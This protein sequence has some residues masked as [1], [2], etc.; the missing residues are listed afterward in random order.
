MREK[1]K[2]GQM[3]TIVIILLMSFVFFSFEVYT[4]AVE[5]NS[6]KVRVGTMNSF[7]NSVEKNLERQLYIVGYRILFLAETEITKNGTYI[8][9]DEFFNEAFFNGTVGGVEN[10]TYLTGARYDD[11]IGFINEKSAKVNVEITLENSMVYVYQDDPWNIKVMMVS[12]FVMKDLADLASWSKTQTIVATIP[13]VGFEDPLYTVNSNARVSRKINKTS[14]EGNY[15]VGGDSSNLYD[16]VAKSYYAANT[17]AP[18][19]L[20]RLEGN[21]SADVNGIESFVNIEEFS[22]QGLSVLEKS[23]IDYTYFSNNDPAY[24][25]VLGM[26]SW[27]LIDNSTGQLEKY[28]V[29]EIL[30]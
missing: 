11:L 2:R 23:K 26:Q 16:H 6:A 29:S 5:N 22:N 9:V 13:I 25:S 18:S 27:F 8:D 21:L 28:N 10:N 19:F 24:F 14:Y 30:N 7:L 20:N 17:N 15:V 12:D 1:G 4:F 3:F